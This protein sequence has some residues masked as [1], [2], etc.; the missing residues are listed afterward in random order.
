MWGGKDSSKM[1]AAF[2][3]DGDTVRVDAIGRWC[4]GGYLC[5]SVQ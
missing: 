3:E 2:A 1:K 4:V 5:R